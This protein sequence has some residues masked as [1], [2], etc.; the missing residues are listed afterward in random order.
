M[1]NIKAMLLIKSIIALI[2]SLSV[3]VVSA[4]EMSTGIKVIPQMSLKFGSQKPAVGAQFDAVAGILFD[5]KYFAG[6]GG[7]YTTDMGMGG[8]TVPLFIDGRYYLYL[9]DN[10]LFRS[11]DVQNNFMLDFQAGMT[12]NNNKP[13]KTGFLMGLGFAYRFD[14]IK[15]KEFDFPA[16]YLGLNIEY[17]RSKLY[18]EYRGYA[19]V[20]ASLSQTFF[21]IKIAFDLEAISVNLL[22]AK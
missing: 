3:F 6:I 15:I 20:D 21:N 19:L 22:K 14:F 11:K 12:I 2:F 9:P 17:N 10:F 5:K 13:Y 18:D 16:F 1:F 7:G 4:Q 8:G